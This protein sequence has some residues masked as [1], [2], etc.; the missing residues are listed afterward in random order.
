ML[1]NAEA[2]LQQAVD[3][4]KEI[5]DCKQNEQAEHRV[6]KKTLADICEEELRNMPE[7]VEQAAIEELCALF[8]EGKPHT[9]ANV[10]MILSSIASL[11][12]IALNDFHFDNEPRTWEEALCS[13]NADK[14]EEGY[15]EELKSLKDMD[16][17]KLIP[18]SNVPATHKIQKGRPV[19]K[20]KHDETGAIVCYKVRL[21][22]QGY[23]QVYGSDYMQTTSPT[24]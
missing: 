17:Y 15:R 10:H 20:A 21:V 2:Q 6:A 7:V 4:S 5:G 16:I 9:K 1:S 3:E 19:F 11:S 23:E 18:R 13:P 24:A 8:S 22:F 14:W 12:S